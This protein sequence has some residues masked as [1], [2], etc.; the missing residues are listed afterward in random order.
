[1]S[2]NTVTVLERQSIFDI[3]LQ[4]YGSIE[5]SISLLSQNSDQLNSITTM[6]LPG[7]V[8]KCNGNPLSTSII[9]LYNET[10][11]KPVSLISYAELAVNGDFN[12]DFNT[13]FNNQ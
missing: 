1:M 8:L 11:Q 10:E 12:N 13:D 6:P 5:A 7:T 9:K 2:N 4:Q 3:A